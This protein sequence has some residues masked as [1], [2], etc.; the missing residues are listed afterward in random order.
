MGLTHFIGL[1]RELWNKVITADRVLE[2]S[3]TKINEFSSKR[4]K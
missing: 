4:A 1:K 2:F 3:D